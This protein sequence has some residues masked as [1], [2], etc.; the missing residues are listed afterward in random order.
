MHNSARNR[1]KI[2]LD[3]CRLYMKRAQ[4]K[5]PFDGKSSWNQNRHNTI[6]RRVRVC[7][8]LKIHSKPA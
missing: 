1:D 4:S 3:S 7:F 6:L 2:D 8:V 5:N